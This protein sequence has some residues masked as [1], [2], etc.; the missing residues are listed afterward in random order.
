MGCLFISFIFL[1]SATFAADAD[2]FQDIKDQV[3][4]IEAQASISCGANEQGPGLI[5]IKTAENLTSDHGTAHHLLAELQTIAEKTNHSLDHADEIV[6]SHYLATWESK[7]ENAKQNLEYQL[8]KLNGNSREQ[9][10][11]EVRQAYLQYDSLRKS[12]GIEKYDPQMQSTIRR[13]LKELR[14]TKL[15]ELSSLAKLGDRVSAAIEKA[16]ACQCKSDNEDCKNVDS[17]KADT[18]RYQAMNSLRSAR[19]ATSSGSGVSV[20]K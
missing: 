9:N 10:R 12:N 17:L 8:R 4:V 14:E 19:G 16:T 11:D 20:G 13:G 6:Q 18:E 7:L 15:I 5:R 1:S 2:H 3:A